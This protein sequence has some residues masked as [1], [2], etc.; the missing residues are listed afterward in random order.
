MHNPR[1]PNTSIPILHI[2]ELTKRYY[3]V[4]SSRGHTHRKKYYDVDWRFYIAH[5]YGQYVLCGTRCPMYDTHNDKW[6]VV[7]ASFASTR[8]VF[9]FISLMIGEN[10]INLTLFVSSSRADSESECIYTHSDLAFSHPTN[11]R[12]RA[13]D[14]D[15]E[16]RRTELVG[17]DR[18]RLSSPTHGS[19][20]SK[21]VR[22][23]NMLYVL[24]SGNMVPFTVSPHPSLRKW[25]KRQ[26][27]KQRDEQQ[28]NEQNEQNAEYGEYEEYEEYEDRS[29]HNLM[30]CVQPTMIAATPLPAQTYTHADDDDAAQ[31]DDYYDYIVTDHHLPGDR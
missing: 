5:K 18:I 11:K 16:N 30:D 15:R 2:E 13:L 29:S 28:Q 14:S 19:S 20:E 17:Y 10:K 22:L 25:Q 4:K 26:E 21:V 6:P 1:N 7:S 8:E 27:R 24:N 31:Y 23:L 12:F 9:E 3:K